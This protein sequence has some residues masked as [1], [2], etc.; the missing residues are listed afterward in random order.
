MDYTT[1]ERVK[2]EMHIQSGSS[3]DDGLITLL[4]TAASRAWDR[5]C[6]GVPDSDNYFA[7]EDVV[8]EKLTGQIDYQG[9]SIICYPHKPIINSVASFSYQNTII[10]KAYTV[11]GS[12]IE[13]SGGRVIAYPNSIPWEF[14]RKCRVTISYNGG[15]GVSGSSLPADMQEVVAILVARFYREAETG[16]ADQIGVAELAQMVY[17]R[18][19]PVR[20]VNTAE[21]YKRRVGWRFVA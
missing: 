20:V 5:I 21:F 10:S 16:L 2:Q 4:V 7:T 18:A 15:L 3:V 1:L 19:Y 11:T 8:G 14:P 9:E 6:T 12:R 17:T 13:C